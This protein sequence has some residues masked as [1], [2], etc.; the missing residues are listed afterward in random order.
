MGRGFGGL[1]NYEEFCIFFSELRESIS[2]EHSDSATEVPAI[3]SSSAPRNDFGPAQ[4]KRPEHS[5]VADEPFHPVT[6]VNRRPAEVSQTSIESKLQRIIER[7]SQ[8]QARSPPMAIR[9][10]HRRHSL[11]VMTAEGKISVPKSQ[12]A[13][14]FRPTTPQ[15]PLL[16]ARRKIQEEIMLL[17]FEC[18]RSVEGTPRVE[19]SRP[20]SAPIASQKGL[21]A[22]NT[23]R[24]RQG[25]GSR[26]QGVGSIN[27]FVMRVYEYKMKFNEAG[28]AAAA[29]RKAA[30]KKIAKGRLAAKVNAAREDARI[31]GGQLAHDVLRSSAAMLACGFECTPLRL[32]TGV[33]PSPTRSFGDC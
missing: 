21:T 29:A 28:K 6:S 30:A 12:S 8:R 19:R 33:R 2:D 11:S 22:K 16:L 32:P 20:C 27:E 17:D 7:H 24:A 9:S 26:D 13:F 14:H 10:A 25:Q 1:L 5:D 18:S 3:P 23:S 4:A 31:L 15:G